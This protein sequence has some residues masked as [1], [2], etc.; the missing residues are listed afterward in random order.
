MSLG[1]DEAAEVFKY[2][3]PREVQKLGAAMASLRQVTRDQIADVLQDFVLEAEQH[4]ALSLDSS[5]YIRSVLN[6]ALG[7][8]KAAGLIE[9]ILQGGDT[10]GIEG[11][12]WMDSTAVAELIRHEHPQIIAT[13]LVHLDRDQA[14]EVLALFTERLRNDVVLRIA[15]LDGIQP[16]ALREL[17]DVLTKLL[18]GSENIKRSPMGGVRTAAEILNYLGGVHEESVIEA[19]R[20]YDSDLAAK[21]VEE[22]FVF[23]NLLD[24]EDRSIQVLLKEIESE[25]LIIALK[26]A[27]VE[28][29]E[30]FFKNMS[31]RAAELLREDL[32]SRGPVRVSEVEAEQ[33]KVLQVVRRLADQGAIMIGGRGDDAYV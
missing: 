24:V 10:S 22:M 29:R 1:E 23:E 6:K 5:E 28:L 17:N 30:K 16:A 33:K 26:G 19:V 25:S 7:N 32:E 27:P 14:S 21:I 4:S 8:D 15:T 11:L 18:S 3:A 31:A 12:K 2:L 9:R 20:N 13:I